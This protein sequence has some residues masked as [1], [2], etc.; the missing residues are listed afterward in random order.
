[1]GGVRARDGASR[2]GRSDPRWAR[3]FVFFG[4]VLMILAGGGVV[5][6]AALFAYATRSVEQE[7]LLGS[8]GIR[9]Q[10]NG[11]VSVTGAKNILL[12]GI[13]ARPAQNSSDL[14]RADSI[15]ALHI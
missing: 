2:R 5:A 7:D 6:K 3:L 12:V 8:A 14:V 11:D 10:R 4:A 1:M 9:A 13:D 15:I